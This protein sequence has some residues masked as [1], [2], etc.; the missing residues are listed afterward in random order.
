MLF[1]E[2]KLL[3]A[4]VGMTWRESHPGRFSLRRA[5]LMEPKSLP[6]N[7]YHTP[8]LLREVMHHMLPAEGKVLV[9]GT[10]GGG[11]HTEAML[12]AGAS[13]IGV[14]QDDQA[15]AYASKRLQ[16]FGERFTAVKG[17]FA[18]LPD[19]LASVGITKVDG[20]LVDIGVSSWQLDEADRGF[21]FNKQGPLDMRMNRDTGRTAADVVNR[22]SEDELIR[23]FRE[24]GDERAARKFAKLIVEHR[25]QSAFVTT[26]DL[27]E[28]IAKHS[29][30]SGRIHPATRVFQALRIEVNDELGVLQSFLNHAAHL[31]HPGGRLGVITFHS[32]EDRMV[33]RFFK[34]ATQPMVDRK[35]WPEPRP[36]PD[37]VFKL[38]TR[39][40][41]IADE[42]EIQTNPRA[43]SAKLRVVEKL[44]KDHE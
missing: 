3:A 43:R 24:Y 22:E 2:T 17:N 1:T 34:H 15:L 16:R 37:C 42:Q 8:V 39:K 23:I 32:L 13:V 9:D 44:N 4:G 20:M 30:R 19:L 31:L 40:P 6:E 12:D 33:K 18:E 26:T 27:S 14:D 36:N 25:Q 10:L 21:S 29:P 5:N 11:G 7:H 35:E 28:L 41:V 38:V